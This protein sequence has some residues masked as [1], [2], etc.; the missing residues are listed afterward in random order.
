MDNSTLILLEMYRQQVVAARDGTDYVNFILCLLH[1]EE[2]HVLC[3]CGKYSLLG[4]E[5]D[6]IPNYNYIHKSIE[7]GNTMEK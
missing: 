6:H 5:R 3:P 2:S 7:L 4:K 1:Y